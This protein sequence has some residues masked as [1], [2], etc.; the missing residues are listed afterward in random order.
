[1]LEGN[2]LLSPCWIF[3]PMLSVFHS[4]KTTNPT[5]SNLQPRPSS[6]PE[7]V[8]FDRHAGRD[9]RLGQSCHVSDHAASYL[10]SHSRTPSNLF[11]RAERFVSVSSGQP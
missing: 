3:I 4:C 8:A 7:R 2:L 11:E 9:V 1:M 6:P 5:M 10:A